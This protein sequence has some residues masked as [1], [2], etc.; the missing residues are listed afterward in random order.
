VRDILAKSLGTTNPFNMLKATVH[1]LKSLRRPEEVARIRDK[2]IEDV[3]PI[4]RNG[5]EAQD[6]SGS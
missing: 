6:H 5:Q 3:L 1:A 2:L 4:K